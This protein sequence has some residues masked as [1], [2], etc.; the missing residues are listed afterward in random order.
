MNVNGNS[1]KALPSHAKKGTLMTSSP[2]ISIYVPL[3]NEHCSF[4]DKL[5]TPATIAMAEKYTS[6][7]LTEIDSIAEDS[8]EHDIEAIRFV[9]GV[10]LMLSGVNIARIINHLRKRLPISPSAEISIDTVP[11]K[12]DEHNFRVFEAVG[13]NR[14]SV[15][16]PSGD[17]AEHQ[18]L[19]CPGDYEQIHECNAM[20]RAFGLD[21]WDVRLLYGLPGQTPLTWKKTLGKA[22]ALNPP[23]IT[24]DQSRA[25]KAR[26]GY[27]TE[28]PLA[29]EAAADDGRERTAPPDLH[30][31]ALE[32]LEEAGYRHYALNHFARPGAEFRFLER[33]LAGG[34]VI[35]LGAG[36]ASD[37]GG[38]TYRNTSSV[39]DYTTYTD[40]CSRIICDPIRPDASSRMKQRVRNAWMRLEGASIG[41]L[42]AAPEFACV[43]AS[44]FET[45][46][47]TCETLTHGG[48]LN[49]RDDCYFLAERSWCTPERVFTAIER[50]E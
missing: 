20:R 11:G 5:R 47:R 41:E 50:I 34:E 8:P 46:E 40:D 16:Y 29:E 4:C 22:I 6:A 48:W 23:H 43:S 32:A 44:V 9:G 1:P 33:L 15:L 3:C 24:L 36:S 35:G 13:V 30:R 49:K 38:V 26:S 18:A 27:S 2:V 42:S 28:K 17:R 19:R 7:L 12:I 14:L 37:F 25:A 31:I 10:P 21:A 39:H 45:L